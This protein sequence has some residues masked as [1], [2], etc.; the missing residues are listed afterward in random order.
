MRVDLARCMKRYVAAFVLL[1]PG[2]GSALVHVQPDYVRATR[3]PPGGCQS[4]SVQHDEPAPNVAQDAQTEHL[5]S[6]SAAVLMAPHVLSELER[7]VGPRWLVAFVYGLLGAI[8]L[9]PGG[10][11]GIFFGRLAYY[12]SAV[13]KVLGSGAIGY[14]VSTAIFED[15]LELLD[16]SNASGKCE[17]D[18]PWRF[19]EVIGSA[20]AV[21]FSGSGYIA[22][23]YYWLQPTKS[24][25]EI[26]VRLNESGL[27][28]PLTDNEVSPPAEITVSPATRLKE[29]PRTPRTTRE[30]HQHAPGEDSE[31]LHTAI[32]KSVVLDRAVEALLVGLLA[33]RGNIG[34]QLLLSIVVANF[35]EA[36]Q[37]S[38]VMRQNRWPA[39]RIVLIWLMVA[40][41]SGCLAMLA[42][43]ARPSDILKTA[44]TWQFRW[45]LAAVLQGV[46]GGA[47]LGMNYLTF[48]SAE[49]RDLGFWISGC[50]YMWG[51][52]IAVLTGTLETHVNAIGHG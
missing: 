8:S 23:V 10:F 33:D 34:L 32:W 13:V 47:M 42:A 35:A 26:C 1:L 17:G 5:V 29:T 25:M 4:P 22:L 38:V 6:Q 45:I 15:V 36:F 40:G 14:A 18:C 51:F 30:I 27:P 2:P 28:E 48:Y 21:A 19:R 50:L 43:L 16:I 52:S 9:I 31:R 20:L 44:S 46:L 24:P 49:F 12:V 3:C 11:I 7:A 39:L 41:L 37:A